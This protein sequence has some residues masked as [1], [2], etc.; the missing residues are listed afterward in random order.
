MAHASMHGARK[1]PGPIRMAHA[2][3]H[4]ARK[5]PGPRYFQLNQSFSISAG[6]LKAQVKVPN[7]LFLVA[8]LA[9]AVL[10]LIWAGQ[11]ANWKMNQN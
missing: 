6:L 8:M 7:I 3:T 10:V 2:S 11:P 1:P 5:P 9:S 4:G